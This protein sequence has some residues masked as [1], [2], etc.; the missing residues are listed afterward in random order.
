MTAAA[1]STV[2]LHGV[3]V[4]EVA[5]GVSD[6]G[7][8]HAGGVPGRLF[9][10]LGAT[11]T[12]VVGP[13]VEEHDA[14]AHE[15]RGVRQHERHPLGHVTGIAESSDRYG[16]SANGVGRTLPNLFLMQLNAFG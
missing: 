3:R 11:V 1:T 8:G 12:R 6:L 14:A 7:L 15:V 10:D 16:E 4:V 5:V 9:A 2:P 13:A